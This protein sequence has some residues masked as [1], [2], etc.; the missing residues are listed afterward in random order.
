MW[1]GKVRVAVLMGCLMAFSVVSPAAG[2]EKPT[3]TD[4]V[5]DGEKR[6][7]IHTVDGF[8]YLSED[9]TLK[10]VREAAFA[11][12]KRQALESAQT[13]IKSKTKVKDFQVEYDVIIAETEGAVRVLEQTDHGIVENVRYRVWMK[14]EVFFDIKPKDSPVEAQ[15]LLMSE[16][17]PLTV[18]VWTDKKHYRKGENIQIF[19]RGNKDFYA[20]VVNITGS[21]H[22]IQL[23]PNLYREERHFR[24]GKVYVIPGEQD[25]FD[26]EVVEPFGR[27]RIIV[28]ASDVP[29][30]DVLLQPIGQG[31]LEFQGP[32]E[33]LS[34]QTR[35]I[36]VV[37]KDRDS[38]RTDSVGGSE[39]YEAVWEITTG[40]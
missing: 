23:L 28:Y 7:S 26:L 3:E 21:G 2:T 39:F 12:A 37:G 27:D 33:S 38:S 9:M 15:S 20:R 13:L 24:S 14:A 36:K 25:R 18:N 8:A 4:A 30:G 1:I 35:A 32:E 6:S 22:V 19:I 17:A 11:N 34:I 5:P 16:D 31:L 10:Q 40:P 29:Q